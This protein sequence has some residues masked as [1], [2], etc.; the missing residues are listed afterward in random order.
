MRQQ[1]KMMFDVLD[2]HKKCLHILLLGNVSSGKS[3]V[4]NALL[5]IDKIPAANRATTLKIFIFHSYDYIQQGVIRRSFDITTKKNY[6]SGK[7]ISELNNSCIHDIITLQCNFSSIRHFG[8]DI[9]L[10]DTPGPN[11]SL[12]R[13]HRDILLN[14]VQANFFSH[15]ACVLDATQQKTNE[16]KEL[17]EIYVTKAQ[18]ENNQAK[19]IFLLNKIDKLDFDESRDGGLKEYVA[20][21]REWLQENGF[22]SPII[23]PISAKA[24][25]LVRSQILGYLLTK[26][27]IIDANFF[28][29]W[30]I[31]LKGQV[32]ES[33]HLPEH[34]KHEIEKKSY[35]SHLQLH[36]LMAETGIRTLEML[37]EQDLVDS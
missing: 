32:L 2:S 1:V 31:A 37:F 12:C 13:N 28:T 35:I 16:E 15:I 36:K 27:E 9:F 4:V 30:L 17:L 3:T 11:T 8:G 34:S 22:L 19:C 20:A 21:T 10:Y 23:I 6:L 7:E 24:A 33:A 18:L 26:T 5:G 29:S 25:L 14:I